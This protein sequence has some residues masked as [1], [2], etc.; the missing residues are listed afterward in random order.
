MWFF[1]VYAVVL[2]VSRDFV[3]SKSE[4]ILWFQPVKVQLTWTWENN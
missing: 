3:V 4:D 2:L 1:Y